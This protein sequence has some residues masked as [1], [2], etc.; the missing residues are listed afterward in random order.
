MTRATVGGINS[1]DNLWY[2]LA[3]NA[4]GIAQIDTSG[5]P[6]PLEWDIQVWNPV[7]EF[8]EDGAAV[9]EYDQNT[10]WLYRLGSLLWFSA[11][12]RT[13]SC[14]ITSP[15]GQLRISKPPL[16]LYI[17]FGAQNIGN[18][19]Q[20]SGWNFSEKAIPRTIFTNSSSDNW[21]IFKVYDSGTAF[22]QGPVMTTDLTEH[23]EYIRNEIWFSGFC[24]VADPSS[25]FDE[26]F[27]NLR[28]DENLTD[29]P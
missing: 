13:S 5:I 29:T 22:E 25:R 6:Q 18:T 11:V 7:Y 2:P 24:R 23:S 9:I 17:A 4:Q 20:F 27:E 3:V 15:R 16:N 21:R 8:S 19:Q 26:L 12:I 28:L 14:V 10:G 1:E